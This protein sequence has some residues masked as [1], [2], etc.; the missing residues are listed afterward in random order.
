MTGRQA[1]SEKQVNAKISV[2]VDKVKKAY[3]KAKKLVEK[4]SKKKEVETVEEE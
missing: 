4:T 3:E 1:T 2:D